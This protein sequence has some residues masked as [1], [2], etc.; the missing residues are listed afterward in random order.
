MNAMIG[1]KAKDTNIG[2]PDSAAIDGHLFY[3]AK[4]KGSIAIC[5]YG[6]AWGESA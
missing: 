2:G 6:H 4:D 5:G 1:K 3:R